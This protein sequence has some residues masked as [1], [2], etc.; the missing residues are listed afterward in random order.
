M[1]N[2]LVNT[3]IERTTPVTARATLVGISLDEF[4]IV[5]SYSVSQGMN[6]VLFVSAT[7]SDAAADM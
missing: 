2:A 3:M 5:F 6:I 4:V 7:A 1:A